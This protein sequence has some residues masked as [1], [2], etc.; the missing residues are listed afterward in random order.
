MGLDMYLEKRVFVKN[1]DYMSDNQKNFISIKKGGEDR[2]DINVNKITYI[3]E[4]L[5][6]WRKANAIHN[7]FIGR[8]AEGE[9]DCKQ[10][11]IGKE[12]LEDLLDRCKKIV[13]ESKLLKENDEGVK[14]IED[15]SI[16]KELLPTAEGYFFGSQNYDEDYLNDIK[17][18][19]PIIEEA[20]KA[21]EN[22]D[23]IYYQ[24][25]W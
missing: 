4:E 15:N 7:F 19:I 9:D 3:I 10:I 23:D 24:A 6:Y 2:K 18:T 20:I 25:S 13:K 21:S 12:F 22:G 8:C 14:F 11:E 5:G 1:Y 16:A 17:M